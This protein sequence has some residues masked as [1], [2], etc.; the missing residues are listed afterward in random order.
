MPDELA[1]LSREQGRAERVRKPLELDGRLV[2]GL[3]GAPLG[4]C[5]WCG[6]PTNSLIFAEGLGQEVPME[7]TCGIAL[8]YAYK[9]WLRNDLIPGSRAEERITRM[10]G[11]A[12]ARIG[13]GNA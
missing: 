7:P 4:N 2:D 10:L 12:P 11:P 8:M 3:D 1:R 9:R 6:R 13:P 5:V